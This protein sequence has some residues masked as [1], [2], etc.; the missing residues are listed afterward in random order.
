MVLSVRGKIRRKVNRS[1][2]K[3]GSPAYSVEHTQT[4]IL[5]LMYLVGYSVSLSG[6]AAANE[7]IVV[8]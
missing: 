3:Y 8:R 6:I 4:E 1:A 7:L 2:D 5:A